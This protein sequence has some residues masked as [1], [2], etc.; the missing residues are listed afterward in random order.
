MAA[1]LATGSI[2][3]LATVAPASAAPPS[4]PVEGGAYVLADVECDP[5]HH[6]V[7]DLTVVNDHLSSSVV[8]VVQ[9]GEPIIVAPN[10]AHAITFTGLA[11]GPVTVPVT[12]DGADATVTATVQCAAPL[13]EVL[14]APAQRERVDRAAGELPSTGTG[15]GWGVLI[16]SLLVAAGAAA[17][18]LARRQHP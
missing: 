12:I 2:V 10:S 18:L 7:L 13:V 5:S 9:G 11:D 4:E 1:A 17:S 6:G 3:W 14:P 16:G 8:A 15:A